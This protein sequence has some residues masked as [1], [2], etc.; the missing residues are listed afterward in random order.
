M[1]NVSLH[2]PLNPDAGQARTTLDY[3]I[4]RL[5]AELGGGRP[6][7]QFAI[8]QILSSLSGWSRG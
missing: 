1:V 5:E 6:A 7:L 3:D 4:E 8:Y 2:L